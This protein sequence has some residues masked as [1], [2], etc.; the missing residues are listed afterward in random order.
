MVPEALGA[1][2]GHRG[3]D[4]GIHGRIVARQAR[5]LEAAMV[6]RQ[7]LTVRSFEEDDPR[8]F[9]VSVA[10]PATLLVAKVQKISERVGTKRLEDKDALDVLRLLR[11][12]ETDAL[13]ATL[14]RLAGDS[15]AGPVTRETIVH[16]ATLFTRQNAIGCEMAIRAA[17][18][19][20]RE[21]VIVGSCM[22]L[23]KDLVAALGCGGHGEL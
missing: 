11:G 4:L 20:E 10:G 2:P 9:E 7:R 18:P 8:T 15:M 3:A 12:T 17:W 6:D 16:L 22:A 1:H 5:G 19:A 14:L 13:A 21:D 23:A